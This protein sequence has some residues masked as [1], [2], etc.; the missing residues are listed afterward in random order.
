MELMVDYGMKPI[1]VLKSATSGNA[2]MFHLKQLG[3]LQKGFLA[4]IIAVK[5]N[6]I[7]DITTMKN[8][9]FVMKD[10]VVYKE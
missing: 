4:D 9:S 8:V 5:G 6:P 2:S 1:D 7:K 3:Q 10:G